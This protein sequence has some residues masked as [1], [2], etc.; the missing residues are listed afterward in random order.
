MLFTHLLNDILKCILGLSGKQNGLD[1]NLHNISLIK[2]CN[3]GRLLSGIMSV[4]ILSFILDIQF[5]QSVFKRFIS[6]T[7]IKAAKICGQNTF[8]CMLEIVFMKECLLLG[9][10]KRFCKILMAFF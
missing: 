8:T 7:L 1:S 4:A 6:F 3:Y 5:F 9:G 2:C 10:K